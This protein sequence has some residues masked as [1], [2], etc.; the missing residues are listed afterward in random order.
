FDRIVYAKTAERDATR[1][2]A[3]EPAAPAGI[4]RDVVI[5]ASFSEHPKAVGAIPVSEGSVE[6]DRVVGQDDGG[7][8]V[9]SASP[10]SDK[11]R[12]RAATCHSLEHPF[13]NFQTAGRPNRRLSTSTCPPPSP[14]HHLAYEHTQSK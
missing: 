2:A 12:R 4:A 6:T 3:V 1:L 9:A 10:S 5:A 8:A 7:P 14:L 11:G 13:R